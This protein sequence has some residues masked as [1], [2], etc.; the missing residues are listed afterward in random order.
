MHFFIVVLRQ[1]LTLLPRLECSGVIS[2][3]CSLDLLGSSDSLASASQIA[4][5]TGAC[6]HAQI[7]FCIF[8]RERVSPCCPGWSQTPGPTQSFSRSLSKYWDCRCVPP[9]LAN[10]LFLVEM[11]FHHVGQA[12]LELLTSGDPPTSAS[13]SVGTTGVSHYAWPRLILKYKFNII[14][15]LPKSYNT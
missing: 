7:I 10:F 8:C 13:Q 5:T 4:G 11:G 9:R 3:H 1:G 12:C 14:S 6:P 2:A 15:I